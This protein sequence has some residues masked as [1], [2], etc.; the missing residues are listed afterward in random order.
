MALTLDNETAEYIAA[1]EVREALARI[2]PI[3]FTNTS[4]LIHHL[5]RSGSIQVSTAAYILSHADRFCFAP[6]NTFDAKWHIEAETKQASL[7]AKHVQ[8]VQNIKASSL[9]A[10][11]A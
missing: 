10:H 1:M 6:P 11:D 2:G 3:E 4:D 5:K 7:L 8:A 9:S